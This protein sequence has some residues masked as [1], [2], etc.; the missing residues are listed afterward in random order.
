M[1]LGFKTFNAESVRTKF[2]FI[3]TDKKVKYV[4]T[5]KKKK[6]KDKESRHDFS[7]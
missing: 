2:G 4:L 1:P 5:K 6:D 7:S 3:I